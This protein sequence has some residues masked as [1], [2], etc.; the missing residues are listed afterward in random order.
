MKKL[1]SFSVKSMVSLS[2]EQMAKI[3]GGDITIHDCSGYTGTEGAYCAY[4]IVGNTITVGICEKRT[5]GLNYYFICTN[6]DR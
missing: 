6:K 3:N 2:K 5:S 1:K 4:Q